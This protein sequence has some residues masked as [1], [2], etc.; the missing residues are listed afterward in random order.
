MQ[1]EPGFTEPAFAV[2][3]EKVAENEAASKLLLVALMLDEMS[4][5]KYI[6]WDGTRF[7][8]FVDLGTGG[9]SEN[10]DSSPPAKD[11]IVFMVVSI[12][13]SWK[14]PCTYFLIDG[15]SGQER[16]NL[17]EICIKR[18]YDSGGRVVSLACDGPSCHFTI[19]KALGT[20]LGVTAL[21]TYFPHPS[22]KTTR[23]FVYLDVSHMLKLVR[24][25]S[26]DF[27]MLIDG[28][29]NWILWKYVVKLPELQG[30]EGLCLAN[31][32]RLS[33]VNW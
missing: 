12:N 2:L 29:G 30:R 9:S 22:N 4:I 31:K 14:V 20:S 25:T 19:L 18:L 3:K 15:L 7:R 10:D 8:G 6:T 17:V 26:G 11:A 32:L 23:I 27:G 1:A 13:G 16:A 5:R 24:N 28:E 33:H 21:E